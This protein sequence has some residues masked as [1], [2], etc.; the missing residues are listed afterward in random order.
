[1]LVTYSTSNIIIKCGSATRGLVFNIASAITIY[2]V[3]ITGCGQKE[4][5]PIK[6]IVRSH[7]INQYSIVIADSTFKNNTVLVDDYGSP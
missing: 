7:L 1:M 3:T 5:S 2:G 6:I 4:V